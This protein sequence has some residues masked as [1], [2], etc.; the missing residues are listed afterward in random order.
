MKTQCPVC[1]INSGSAFTTKDWNRRV[2]TEVFKYQKCMKC[3]LIFLANPPVD[4]GVYYGESYYCRPLFKKIENVAKKTSFQL[5]MIKRFVKDGR[6]LEVGPGYGVFAL[7]AK[8]GGFEVDVIEREGKCCDFLAKII[9]VKVIKSDKP[10]EVI[11]SAKEY[12]V[13]ALWQVI[14]H[15]TDPWEFLKKA[16]K[17]LKPNGVI[18]IA[19]PNPAAFQF[20][21]QGAQWPHVDAPRHLWLIPVELLINYV[22]PFGLEPV[23]VTFND[24][25]ARAWNRF[26]WQRYLM[27]KSSNK[28]FQT[29]AF[30]MGH[31]ISLAVGV[32][33]T[34]KDN[35]SAYTIILK[36]RASV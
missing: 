26:G 6:L 23:M 13:I 29:A 12:D 3:G 25:G 9:G 27:N 4:L 16:A 11:E 8:K 10:H 30:I 31:F 28:L 7:Q 18:L 15:L 17:N 22:E 33:E 19:A 14:E 24:K 2:S 5:A 1:K 35:G 32:F 34:K 21:L 36:K 20:K